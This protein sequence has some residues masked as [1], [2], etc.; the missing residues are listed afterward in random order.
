M[1]PAHGPVPAG[2]QVRLVVRN[3]GG[4]TADLRLAGYEDRVRVPAIAPGETRQVSF[5]AD[6]PGDDFTWLVDARPC[7][8]LSVTGSHLVEGHR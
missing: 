4:D 1:Y 5:L 2:R 8:R 3:A 7:G 6:R